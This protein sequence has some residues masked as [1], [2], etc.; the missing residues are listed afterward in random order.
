MHGNHN[1]ATWVAGIGEHVVAADDPIDDETGSRQRPNDVTTIGDRQTTS[2]HDHAATVTCRISGGAS[3]GIAR[4][5][6]RR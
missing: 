3:L 5:L 2:G 1:R 4:P 6:S